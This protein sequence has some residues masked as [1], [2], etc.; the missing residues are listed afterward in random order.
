MF[1]HRFFISLLLSALLLVS[2]IF[3]YTGY[4]NDSETISVNMELASMIPVVQFPPQ[5]VFNLDLNQENPY[6]CAEAKVFGNSPDGLGIKI[7]GA[8]CLTVNGVPCAQASNKIN[9]K[10]GLT[11]DPNKRPNH[12]NV[13]TS[14]WP[15]YIQ[16]GWGTRERLGPDTISMIDS[17][18]AEGASF[19]MCVW[20]PNWR[21]PGIPAG[22]YRA[23]LTIS[24]TEGTTF[25]NN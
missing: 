1:F 24:V 2:G 17:S 5:V 18:S 14:E 15:T 4:A 11:L 23:S 20:I 25:P 10:Y 21:N 19:W 8:E 13:L 12:K 6:G 7:E 16:T 3:L 9:I 22:E